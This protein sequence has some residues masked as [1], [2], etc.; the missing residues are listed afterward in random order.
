[1]FPKNYWDMDG[2][3]KKKERKKATN[4]LSRDKPLRSP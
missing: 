4:T 1:M 2:L 3:E